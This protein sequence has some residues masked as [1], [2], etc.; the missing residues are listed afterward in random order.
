MPE[1]PASI[2]QY[3]PFAMNFIV[4]ILIFVVGSS[5]SKWAQLLVVKTVK[6]RGLDLALGKFFGAMTRYAVLAAA[7]IA[8]LGQVGIQTTSLMAI[9]ASAGLA[10]GLAL[11]GSLANFAAGV[12]ILF[13]RPFDLL[14]VITAAGTTGRVQ[15]IGL[16]AT[17]LATPDHKIHVIPN[18][19]VTGGTIVNLS[20][21]GRIRGS[22]D[23]GVAYGS[24][25]QQVMEV[26]LAAAAK[27]SHVMTD[28]APA[29]AFVGMGA[30][31]IDF[32][33]HCFTTPDTY[34]D[35]L[36]DVRTHCYNAL[37][38]NGIE[39]PYQTVTILRGDDA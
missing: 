9:F 2:A 29:M 36:H 20:K 22:V 5:V 31:S 27:S 25:V 28:P 19:A 1:I 24:N 30:S 15:E 23:I 10:V 6:K 35:M 8:A 4:G 26:C 32:Q 33:V 11:Q 37:G 18:A 14:D 38:E 17:T 3:M 21:E 34:L 39:I 7:V 12:M 16:F 13:F